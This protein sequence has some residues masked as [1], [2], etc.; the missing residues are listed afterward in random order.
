MSITY[1][2]VTIVVLGWRKGKAPSMHM[3]SLSLGRII[4]ILER[5][6]RAL[7]LCIS[8]FNIQWWKERIHTQSGRFGCFVDC[9]GNF[10]A[11]GASRLSRAAPKAQ[12]AQTAFPAVSRPL[13]RRAFP[14][15]AQFIPGRIELARDGD[16]IIHQ[17]EKVLV[18]SV[19]VLTRGARRDELGHPSEL[20]TGALE[21]FISARLI[22]SLQHTPRMPSIPAMTCE[23]AESPVENARDAR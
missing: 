9:G 19:V 20:A 23:N 17:F 21:D 1:R 7:W 6:S 3:F 22:R 5:A 2:Y 10:D 12:R 11:I 14:L 15:S 4:A 18:V 16:D 8:S 13:G